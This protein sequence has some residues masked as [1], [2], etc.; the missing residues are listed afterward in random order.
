MIGL[1]SCSIHTVYYNGYVDAIYHPL[2]YKEKKKKGS[3]CGPTSSFYCQGG[4]LL[5]YTI[6]TLA[7]ATAGSIMPFRRWFNER[8][9]KVREFWS[10][11]GRNFSVTRIA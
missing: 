7:S 10:V 3:Y 6:T 4:T 11:L 9:Y 8:R 1:I 2:N 5:I